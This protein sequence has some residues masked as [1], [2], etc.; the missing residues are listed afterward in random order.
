M[1]IFSEDL[2]VRAR[3]FVV[4]YSYHRITVVAYEYIYIY[5]Y[6]HTGNVYQ[7]TT[8]TRPRCTPVDYTFLH[9]YFT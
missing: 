5:I 9:V 4:D 6:I 2:R 8:R 7:Y 1:C 3:T